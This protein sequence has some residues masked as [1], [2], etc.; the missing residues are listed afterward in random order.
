MANVNLLP[1]DL[2]GKTL[3][4][5]AVMRLQRLTIVCAI[6]MVVG[7]IAGLGAIYYFSDQLQKSLDERSSLQSSI[8]NLQS[9][10]ATLVL[11]KDR[12]TQISTL[13]EQ[14]PVEQSVS[15]HSAI[16]STLSP[17][18]SFVAT[19]IE[20]DISRLELRSKSSAA[21][22]ALI[23]ELR[24]N[25]NYQSVVLNSLTFNSATGYDFSIDL[26]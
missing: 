10:E 4:T 17:D 23:T 16:L 11:V 5:P 13:I 15:R 19:T 22:V 20:A 21:I 3:L 24:A 14:K 9:S 12:L 18:I 1:Q 6:I 26:F 25:P 7:G 8:T 2:K